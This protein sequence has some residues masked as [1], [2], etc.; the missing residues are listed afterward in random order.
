VSKENKLIIDKD[1]RKS[2][3]HYLMLVQV[4][5]NQLAD[6]TILIVSLGN[7]SDWLDT[8]VFQNGKR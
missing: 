7:S 3:V 4:K 5:V 8:N 6:D 1:D 2:H